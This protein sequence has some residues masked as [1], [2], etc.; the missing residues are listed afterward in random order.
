LE[1]T[2]LRTSRTGLA[3]ERPWSC[4]HAAAGSAETVNMYPLVTESSDGFDL[5]SYIAYPSWVKLDA[6]G[7][8]SD[9]QRVICLR[10]RRSFR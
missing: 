8:P 1:E 5:V 9:P 6:D 3:A 4:F 10:S 7:I 2:S